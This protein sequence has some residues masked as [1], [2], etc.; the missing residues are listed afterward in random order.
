MFAEG[1]R[2]LFLVL[3]QSQALGSNPESTVPC[4]DHYQ[5]PKTVGAE[6][7]SKGRVCVMLR[8]LL[9]WR[10]INLGF[11]RN[12]CSRFFRLARVSDSFLGYPVLVATWIPVDF[13]SQ[14]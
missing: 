6:D 3:L 12:F 10:K 13:D 5:P 1:I 4:C 7:G 11:L 2:E 8:I 9:V 14:G